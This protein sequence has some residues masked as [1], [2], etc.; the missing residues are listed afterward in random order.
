MAIKTYDELKSLASST[1]GQGDILALPHVIINSSSSDGTGIIA[2]SQQI[3]DIENGAALSDYLQT[4]TTASSVV[5]GDSILS[6]TDSGLKTTLSIVYT[7]ATDTTNPKISL[8]G[9]DGTSFS[10]IEVPEFIVDGMLKSVEYDSTNKKLTFT[11]NTD[12]GATVTTI[13]ISDLVD[14]YTAGNGLTVSSNKFSVVIDNASE[15]FLSVS[16]SGVKLSGVQDAIDTAAAGATTVVAKSSSASHL[17]LSSSTNS[18]T[19]ATTY[20]IGESDIASANSLTSLTTRVTS[21]E[22]A[23]STETTNRT[24]ADSKL[25]TKITNVATAAGVIEGTTIAYQTA[26]SANY[27]GSATSV[28]NA[29]VLLDSAV[30]K[31]ADSVNAVVIVSTDSDN[32]ITGGSDGGAYLSTVL[33]AGEY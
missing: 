17:T 3:Y 16:S 23:I 4:L 10:T 33:D 26:S 8:V 9:V 2:Y 12:A 1:L 13:D 11:W 18:T 15:S 24:N 25:E 20:T 6:S 21:A 7:K 32:A 22:S 30:K 5:K 29:T 19:G 31:V 14:T 27:I 28:H